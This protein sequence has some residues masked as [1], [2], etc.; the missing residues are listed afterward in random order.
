VPGFIKYYYEKN[1]TYVPWKLTYWSA[2]G[3]IVNKEVIYNELKELFN[4][5]GPTFQL[6]LIA[7]SDRWNPV[8]LQTGRKK[9]VKPGCFPK[10]C[11]KGLN[12]TNAFPCI[13]SK[14]IAADYFIYSIA[15]EKTYTTTIP[16]MRGSLEAYNSTIDAG[17]NNGGTMG[18]DRI[19]KLIRDFYRGYL[20]RPHFLKLR[21]DLEKYY[22]TWKAPIR[23]RAPTI[24]VIKKKK[25][26]KQQAVTKYQTN[27]TKG[28]T[29]KR[30]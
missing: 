2:G 25:S 27:T 24:K 20:P 7:G 29:P 18:L 5:P 11:C 12:F 6:D 19:E 15:F 28:K 13:N 17:H 21:D 30:F 23:T 10:Q 14:D 1:M 3:Y 9:P 22:R 4:Q 26:K 16:L 8:F